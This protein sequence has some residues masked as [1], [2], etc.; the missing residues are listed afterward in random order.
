MQKNG[1]INFRVEVEKTLLSQILHHNSFGRVCNIVS[2]QNF[3]ASIAFHREIFKACKTL[4]PA[5]PVNALTVYQ[6]LKPKHQDLIIYNDITGLGNYITNQH[7]ADLALTLLQIDLTD[8][9]RALILNKLSAAARDFEHEKEGAL[10][11]I[12][13]IA[14]QPG[15]DVFEMIENASSYFAQQYPDD[16][17]FKNF[18]TD[19]R[20]KILQ[21]KGMNQL[22]NILF[23]LYNISDT[24]SGELKKA[25]HILADAIASIIT[26]QKLKPNIANALN[27]LKQ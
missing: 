14:T 8:K 19:L 18:E 20:K 10:K 12:Y 27:C 9:F 5:R 13:Q 16:E 3:S 2:E 24:Q 21:I 1:E 17:D 6:L 25:C 7:E 11:E 26:T 15:A 23:E 22:N 4:Y